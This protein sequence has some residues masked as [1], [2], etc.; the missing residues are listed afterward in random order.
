MRLF[1]WNVSLLALSLALGCYLTLASTEQTLVAQETT[2]GL[3]GT[4][5][6]PSGAVLPRATITVTAPTLVGSK[7][8]TSDAS[9]FYHF[10]NLPPGT[11]AVKVE[12]PGFDTLQQAGLV[13]EVGH[14]PTVDLTLKIGATTNIIEVSAAAPLIDVTTDTT[15]TNITEDV[16]QN[17]PHGTSFQSA[18]QFAPSARNEPLEGMSQFSIGNGNGA[19]SPGSGSSGNA[20]GFSIA[21]GADSENAYLVEGQETANLIAGY[22]HTNVPFDF[23]DEMV[24]DTSGVQA[25][26]GGALGGVINVIMQKGTNVLHG[27][28]WG[29]FNDDA[30]NGSPRSEPRYDPNGS[31][32]PN[33]DVTYQSYQP[34]RYHTSDVF[35]GFRVG[36][37]LI[38]DRLFLF[39]AFSPEWSDEERT[40]TYNHAF[41]STYPFQNGKL[42]FGQNTQTYY[43]NLRADAALGTKIHVFG[44][45]L[46]QGQRQSG[47]NLPFGDSVNGLF[48]V[49]SSV[50]PIG[51]EHSL[52]YSA[53][54]ATYNVG[55]D[56]SAT[57][58]I[59]LTSRFGYFFE[60]YHDLGYPTTGEI[61]SFFG[62]GVGGTT[63]DGTSL[64]AD[65]QEPNGYFNQP[66]SQT[67]TIYD[68]DKRT[69]FDQD[70]SVTKSGRWGTHQIKFGYQLNRSNNNIYQRWPA[71]EVEIFP[72]GSANYSPAGSTGAAN[73]AA[74]EADEDTDNC[75][76]QYGYVI[77]SDY[78]TKGQATSFNH[79]FYGQDAWTIGK[80]LSINFGLR[81]EKE[82]VPSENNAAGLPTNPIEF[83]WNDKIA[84][85]FGFA[86]DP[87]QNGKMKI[88]GGYGSF[89]DMMKLNVAI[90]SFGGQYWQNCAYALN[91]P[92]LTDVAPVFD[93]N[94][95]Y[96]N[97]TT[98]NFGGAT[99]PGLVFLESLNNRGTEGVVPG[100]KPYR[101][102]DTDFG[103][104]YE[105]NS[106]TS[107]EARWDRR[108]LDHVIE[109]AAL[110]DPSGN[111]IFTI[112]N[113]GE[114]PNAFNATCQTAG[115][116]PNTGDNYPACPPNVKPA[117]SYDGLEFLVTK[118]IGSHWSGQFSYTYSSFRGNYCGLT[119]CLEADGGGGRNAP[120]NSRAFDETYFQF[121]AYG[122]PANGKLPTDRPNAF[123]GY[124]YYDLPEG[125]S[126]STTFGLFQD[127]Y[128]GTPQTSF[129]NVGYSVAG[130]GNFGEFPVNPEG[131]GKWVDITQN[132]STGVITVGNARTFRT[133][134]FTQSDL[135]IKQSY[136]VKE[137]QTISFD[138]TITN[139]LNQ[140]EVVAYY[141]SVDTAY[142]ATF[143]APG[144]LPFYYGGE[145][146]S[147]YEHPYDWK[148]LLNT[149][150]VTINSQYGKPY[151]Y[152]VGRNI[153]FQVHYNF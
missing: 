35:P 131:L 43:T 145:A 23:I 71:P 5:K 112:V 126:L 63:V 28:I 67:Y 6:D 125:H 152:Q 65:L 52:G 17:I 48:N 10:A 32:N 8:T 108:R 109:D 134:W 87:R 150:G 84:P 54:N 37:P 146:Y 133:P 34:K 24:V 69:Q 82:N 41:P 124:A 97:A 56:Y 22:S 76:G 153:R 73:C 74:V 20:Y 36:M 79:A 77:I 90:G 151:E 40:V 25:E 95:R 4:V 98:A 119:S 61:D 121:D 60:N 115:V 103:V 102:H 49:S 62:S 18:I 12:A 80:G 83:G 123:K 7:V 88:F 113:P 120:N 26:H 139:A 104:D 117:R 14:L 42:S 47:E 70:V 64:P 128:S 78:G 68:A 138:A 135:N 45:V 148:A 9:G 53:P 127:A 85:R 144:G 147:L 137:S 129:V 116:D 51:F 111:E 16:V 132:P 130:G 91:D 13:I 30:L 11:Y 46:D 66:S 105:I 15:H 44:S 55:L 75:T 99:P 39:A 21:G 27:S 33:T 149:D 2:G 29:Q 89:T 92:D 118:N 142:T 106:T 107:F 143:I 72:G 96:C 50:N 58:S 122:K 140:H 38:K 3:Q 86:W 1:R 141:G 31:F 101:Q 81:V 114:G 94:F 110:F 93:S 100:L 136:K 57:P 59:I 19:T